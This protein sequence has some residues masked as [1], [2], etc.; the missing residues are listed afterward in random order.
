MKGMVFLLIGVIV[1]V[2]GTTFLK[3][4]DGF[5]KWGPT[6]MVIGGYII[7]FYFLALSLKYLPL[8]IGYALWSGIGMVLTVIAGM[9][10]W[11][12]TLSGTHVVGMILIILG[13]LILNIQLPTKESL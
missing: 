9:I 10:I 5:T 3:A 7:A 13:I 4:S 11:K 6:L 1:E 12:E 8:G 2:I